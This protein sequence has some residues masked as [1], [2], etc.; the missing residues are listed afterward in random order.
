[1]CIRDRCDLAAIARRVAARAPI[2]RVRVP[3]GLAAS[4]AGIATVEDAKL[5]EGDAIVELTGG[6]VD[7][8]L[9]VR[10]AAVLE[11]FA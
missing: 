6:A 8:R 4:P 1:M 10:L 3:A 5:A 2:V 7:A 9:G 11:A